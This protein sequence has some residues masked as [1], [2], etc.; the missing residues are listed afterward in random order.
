MLRLAKCMRAHGVPNFPDPTSQGIRISP[1]SGIN[2]NSPAFLAAQKR[3]QKDSLTVRRRVLI[4]ES[5]TRFA[6]QRAGD[7]GAVRA[8]AV[9]GRAGRAGRDRAQTGRA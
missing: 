2:L 3:C 7:P 5:E 8:A 9:A 6:P 4:A 1:S